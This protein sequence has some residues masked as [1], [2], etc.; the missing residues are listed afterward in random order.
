M[1]QCGS[2]EVSMKVSEMI[3]PGDKIEIRLLQ[4]VRQMGRSGEKVKLYMSKVLDIRDNGLFEMAMPSEE[5]KLV[6]LQAGV[7][8]EFIFVGK[9]SMYQAVGQ[10]RQRYKKDNIYMLLAE[11]RSMPEKY[12]RRE[13][14][15]YS[16]LMDLFYYLITGEEADMESGNAIFIRM[17]TK[18]QE[19]QELHGQLADISGGGG[20]LFSDRELAKEQN[21]LIG[22]HL[23]SD[24]ID[25]EYYIPAK[26]INCMPADN[27]NAAKEAKYQSHLKFLFKDNRISE[28]IVKYIF[29][30]ERAERQRGAR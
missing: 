6:A 13:F 21:L 22:L 3:R 12:Q 9:T 28:E 30:K 26:V 29:E 25:K 2:M 20:R 19:R 5:G 1:P 4:E 11:L 24:S 18:G 7:R 23:K 17:R 8:Y 27:G 16:C 15:R 10:I 14:F